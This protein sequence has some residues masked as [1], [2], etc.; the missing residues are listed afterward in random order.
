MRAATLRPTFVRS[1]QRWFVE[2]GALFLLTQAPLGA[3]LVGYIW[4]WTTFPIAFVLFMVPAFVALPVY[5]A[6]RKSR[7]DD[8]REPV[9]HL[10]KYAL[11]ALVPFVVYNVFRILMHYAL[12]TVF[13]DG[14]FDY[15]GQLTGEPSAA[16]WS[17][18][19]GMVVHWL[20]GYVLALGYYVL[21][22]RYTLAGSLLYVFVFLSAV[23]SWVF[24]TFVMVTTRPTARYFFVV[25]GAHLCMAIAAWIM[26][27]INWSTISSRLP[28]RVAKACAIAVFLLLWLSPN[29]FAF[30]RTAS[31]QHP[32]QSSIDREVFE[33]TRLVLEEGPTLTS[34][35][36][37][38]GRSHAKE[39]HYEFT[40]RLGPRVYD[41]FRKATRVLEVG[42][43]A[44]KGN[45]LDDGRLVAYCRSFIVALDGPQEIT[46]REEYF[47]ALEDMNF[48]DIPVQCVGPAKRALRLKQREVTYVTLRWSASMTL[49]G[50]RHE[51]RKTMEGGAEGV[52]IRFG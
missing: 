8:L 51:M 31:W 3:L 33:R 19:S 37:I 32:L 41:D 38:P 28:G 18:I 50:G 12:G 36:D 15:G 43:V 2:R 20:Q 45:I 1:A 6:V 10:Q 46:E 40:L 35:H 47:R 34:I 22:A 26:P 24:P 27:R 48:S 52:P 21:F 13:W 16:F 42:G 7:S 5:V 30:W 44:I 17:L 23:Y 29:V 49:V 39:A 25:W 14:W 11:W 4:D 9:H